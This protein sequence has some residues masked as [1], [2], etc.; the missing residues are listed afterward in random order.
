[1]TFPRIL[2]ALIGAPLVL[3]TIWC[4][5]LPYLVF[6]L[7]ITFLA[8]WEFYTLSELGGYPAQRWPGLILGLFLVFSFYIGGSF[9][10]SVPHNP[11]VPFLLTL[12]GLCLFLI[13]FERPDKGLSLLRISTT[14]LGLF[15]VAWPFS[16]LLL[17]RDLRLD[18]STHFAVGRDLTYLAFGILWV[19]DIGAWLVGNLVGKRRMSPAISP[20]K[21]WEGAVGG[22]L[23]CVLFGLLFRE[24]LLKEVFGRGETILI[25]LGLSVLAQVSDLAASFLKRSFG[26]KD[27]S[28]LL[29]GHGGILDRFDSFLF[30]IPL[31]YYYLIG[32]GRFQ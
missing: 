10:R 14:L 3:F 16:H 13:E 18:D 26:M 6:T 27:F 12:I 23:F 22:V 21:T 15:I 4:G 20:R 30:S 1:M 28:S 24:I 5:N 31:F 11:G 7:G 17:I 9:T 29:P 2:T 19:Q 25:S 8:L 32:T